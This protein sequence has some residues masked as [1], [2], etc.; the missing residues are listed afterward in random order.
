MLL[1]T[2]TDV[3]P[4][5]CYPHKKQ[6][7]CLTF[8]Y[9]C[10]THGIALLGVEELELMQRFWLSVG[11]RATASVDFWLYS[12]QCATA[13]VDFWLY[14]GQRATAS[15]DFWPYCGQRATASVDF[16]LYFGQRAKVSV[17]LAS[18]C[19]RVVSS[20]YTNES[21]SI[22]NFNQEQSRPSLL[23]CDTA[24]PV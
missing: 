10:P 17:D 15:V 1:Y 4:A 13:S 21:G 3:T 7:L 8:L 9:V 6:G 2:N 22:S 24:L 12:G 20:N 11:Q 19:F 23:I 14:F 5:H 18:V 16:W